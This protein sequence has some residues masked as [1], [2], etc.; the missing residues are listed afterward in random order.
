M[1]AL[2]LL[3]TVTAQDL[4]LLLLRDLLII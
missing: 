1:E 2:P 4:Q 3:D